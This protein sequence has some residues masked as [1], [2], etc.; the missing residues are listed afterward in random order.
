MV[1]G[2]L[3]YLWIDL[4]FV[5]LV[6][7]WFS[8]VI[9]LWSFVL[10]LFRV[11]V[12]AFCGC[13]MVVVWLLFCL[14]LFVCFVWLVVKWLV[15]LCCCVVACLACLFKFCMLSW[16]C[17]LLVLT[18]DSWF[19]YF[20]DVRLIVGDGL[21]KVCVGFGLFSWLLLFDCGVEYDVLLF[22]CI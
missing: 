8:R 7:L 20:V 14:I 12:F 15:Y 10:C 2:G 11:G 13:L 22:Y 6:I 18:Y 17:F 21:N 3:V 16:R 9:W 1:L 5:C 4:G 19:S